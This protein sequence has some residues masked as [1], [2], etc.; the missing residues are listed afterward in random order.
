MGV[1]VIRGSFREEPGASE[2]AGAQGRVGPQKT[3][4]ACKAC[5]STC[6]RSGSRAVMSQ[7]LHRGGGAVSNS[8]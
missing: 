8:R 7:G 6:E 4:Q 5:S 1:T 3:C 2:F